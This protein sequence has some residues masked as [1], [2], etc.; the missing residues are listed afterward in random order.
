MEALGERLVEQTTQR[1]TSV[2][3][4][5]RAAMRDGPR[6]AATHARLFESLPALHEVEMGGT[7]AGQGN[8]DALRV[9]AWNVERL[10]HAAAVADTLAGEAP[11]VTLLSEVDK[12]MVRSGNGHPLRAV[13]ELLGHAYAYG[14]EFVELSSGDGAE[15]AAAHGAA[16]AEGFHGNAITSALPLHRPFLIRLD[17][18]GGWFGPQRG[19]PR[20]GGRMAVGAQVRLANRSVT[21][22]CVHL[23]NRT[24]PAGRAAQAE[25]LLDALDAYDANA[26]VLIG[27]DFN[28]L[29]ASHEERHSDLDAWKARLAA[30]PERLIRVEAFEPLFGVFAR[31]GF[32]WRNANVLGAPT[33]R[34]PV[35]DERAVGRIDWF[36]LR[37]LVPEDAGILPALLPDGSPSSDHDAIT[38]TVRLPEQEAKETAR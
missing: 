11:D 14:V 23:E 21:V 29:T 32:G 25:L 15:R 2:P 36:F 6:D 7:P 8:G 18:E 33:Q 12:G 20:V 34:R 10:R 38:V 4:F 16:D 30:D 24:G 31:R 1:L 22:V 17:R 9:V 19:Q 35:G 5:R 27:G 13:S 3:L 28:T 37:G 26:P